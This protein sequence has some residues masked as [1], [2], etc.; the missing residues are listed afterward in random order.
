MVG[1]PNSE[2]KRP[3]NWSAIT[4]GLGDKVRARRGELG[5]SQEQLRERS[6]IS[7]NQIQNIENARGN[8]TET[9]NPKL[10]ALWALANALEIDISELFSTR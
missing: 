10:D 5:M 6:G 3:D 8:S 9:S 2:V 4:A 7:R 1:V